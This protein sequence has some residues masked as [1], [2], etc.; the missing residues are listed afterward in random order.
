MVFVC[1]NGL[2]KL[3]VGCIKLSEMRVHFRSTEIID[4]NDLH[5]IV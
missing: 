4:R 5:F 3:T 2:I 1:R